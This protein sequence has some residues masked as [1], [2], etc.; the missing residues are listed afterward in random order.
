M[1]KFHSFVWAPIF[2]HIFGADVYSFEDILKQ[3]TDSESTLQG[4]S[5]DTH[6]CQIQEKKI[7]TPPNENA[8]L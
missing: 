1:S 7:L 6:E 8:H 2:W 3:I 4:G 5:F